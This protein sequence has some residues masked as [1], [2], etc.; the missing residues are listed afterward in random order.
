VC[1]AQREALPKQI[2]ILE[3]ELQ[4]NLWR[5]LRRKEGRRDPLPD[6][7]PPRP[8]QLGNDHGFKCRLV[9]D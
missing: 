8:T 2:P 9:S 5:F 4:R 1:F 3:N 7:S 6:P